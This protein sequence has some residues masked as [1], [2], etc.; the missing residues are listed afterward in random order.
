M[1]NKIPGYAFVVV[2]VLGCFLPFVNI[3][4]INLYTSEITLYLSIIILFNT[5]ASFSKQL[6][7]SFSILVIIGFYHA[8][9]N[10]ILTDIVIPIRNAALFYTSFILVRYFSFQNIRNL[11]YITLMAICLI[12][13]IY[14]GKTVWDLI[15]GRISP[16]DF[17]Y[18]YEKGRIKAFFENGTTS[19]VIGSLLSSLFS[20][21]L[22]SKHLKRRKALLLA[23]F[24][25]GTMTAS[26]SNT[27]A[28]ITSLLTFHLMTKPTPTLKWGIQTILLFVVTCI[29]SYIILLK[30]LLAD[31]T[32]DGS[33]SI[34]LHYYSKALS[35]AQNLSDLLIGHGY[36]E[37]VLFN[38]F[39]ISFFE[40]YFFN[41]YMQAGI[42]G[43][44]C[45][46]FILIKI[47]WLHKLDT[48]QHITIVSGFLIGNL[49]GGSNL[50]SI[51][52]LPFT[53]LGLRYLESERHS[54]S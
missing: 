14:V 8:F 4:N 28:N 35:S 17:L 22:C 9:N 53:L 52:V 1:I 48:R 38:K 21:T 41:S 37:E 39:G 45:F 18:D 34:R 44:F 2:S 23:L 7:L 47:V 24:V 36:S 50:F 12:Y 10:Q 20:I 42:V 3:G 43:L 49:L 27:L 11:F 32:I 30:I 13:T 54:H 46:T 25:L 29:G 51:F 6:L 16:I 40:S 33:A 31:V 5:T 15:S 19:V 26:R